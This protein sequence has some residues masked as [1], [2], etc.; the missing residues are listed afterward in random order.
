MKRV[1]I[2]KSDLPLVEEYI[3]SVLPEE[4]RLTAMQVVMYV[5]TH[6]LKAEAKYGFDFVLKEEVDAPDAPVIV[7]EDVPGDDEPAAEA[8]PR[9]VSI[10]HH[11][12]RMI[13]LDTEGCEGWKLVTGKNKKTIQGR[14]IIKG[15][16]VDSMTP[17]QLNGANKDLENAF[18]NDREHSI[19]AHTG[20]KLP[21]CI[22]SLDGRRTP[23][24][25]WFWPFRNV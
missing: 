9:I 5:L 2:K 7:D 19:N 17:G 10:K 3:N 12:E 20:E 22:E 24:F 8:G 25:E 11:G 16:F 21:V 15:V 4:L 6:T 1:S 18:G 14:L 13:R 23:D